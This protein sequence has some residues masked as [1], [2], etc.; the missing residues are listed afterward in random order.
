[1]YKLSYWVLY[2]FS[3]WDN[4]LFLGWHFLLSSSDKCKIN[5]TVHLNRPI[6]LFFFSPWFTFQCFSRMLPKCSIIY[7]RAMA[8]RWAGLINRGDRHRVHG[9]QLR[10]WHCLSCSGLQAVREL[11]VHW[12]GNSVWTHIQVHAG[13]WTRPKKSII[14]IHSSLLLYQIL[15]VHSQLAE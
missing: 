7:H 14:F 10:G 8:V 6:F 4:V 15:T 3:S 12:A 2:W 13:I 5:H 11:H 9:K 1:M